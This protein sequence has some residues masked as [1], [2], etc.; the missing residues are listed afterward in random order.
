MYDERSLV[1]YAFPTHRTLNEDVEVRLF[2]SGFAPPGSQIKPY[3]VFG[4]TFENASYV[5]SAE[6]KCSSPAHPVSRVIVSINQFSLSNMYGATSESLAIFDFIKGL[7]IGSIAPKFLSVLYHEVSYDFPLSSRIYNEF[8]SL[9][10]AFT[11]SYNV[12]F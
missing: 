1:C 11:R 5:S 9:S 7:R 3:C 10:Y 12:S 2:G 6:F 8:P 4:D